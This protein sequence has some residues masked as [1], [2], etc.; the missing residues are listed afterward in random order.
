MMNK[1]LFRPSEY[2]RVILPFVVMRRLD[3]VLEPK[4]DEVC[5]LFNKYKDQISDPS[6]VIL[7]QIG[8]PFFNTSRFDLV[9]IKSDPNIIL[10]NFNNYINGYSKNVFDIIK[11]FSINPLVEKL[12]E[13]GRLYQLI[14]KLTEFDLHPNVIDNH[15][16]GTHYEELLRRFSEMSNEESGDHFTPRDIVKLLVSFVFGGDEENLKGRINP[17]CV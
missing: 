6:P 8:L 11:N 9:R 7:S 5:D 3:C 14:D 15:K 1:G 2:G 13:H 10:A 16:M 17:V 4:K 12:N